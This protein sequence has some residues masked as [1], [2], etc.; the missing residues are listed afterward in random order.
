MPTHIA[1][2]TT[3]NHGVQMPWF[4]FGVYKT[5]PGEQ[6]EMR[7]AIENGYRPID[8]AWQLPG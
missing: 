1:D 5:P 6:V 8:T 4:G 2:C 3:L 7:A